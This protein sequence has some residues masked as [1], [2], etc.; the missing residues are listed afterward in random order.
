MIPLKLL[1][2][3]LIL[4]LGGALLSALLL[5]LSCSSG[6]EPMATPAP[7]QDLSATLEVIV[8]ATLTA[9]H[10][11]IPAPTSTVPPTASPIRKPSPTFTPRPTPGREHVAIAPDLL[12]GVSYGKGGLD[13][14]PGI[15]RAL[16]PSLN[17]RWLFKRVDGDEWGGAATLFGGLENPHYVELRIDDYLFTSWN[18]GG[19]IRP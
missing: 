9:L 12:D 18:C 16:R 6:P 1:A 13:A 8:S 3:A 17:C 7:T 11:A 2:S 5:A 19:W 14:V 4:T 10:V 15:Y